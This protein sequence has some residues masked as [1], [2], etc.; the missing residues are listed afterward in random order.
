ML[1]LVEIIVI[2]IN[3]FALAMAKG[4]GKTTKKIMVFVAID[5]QSELFSFEEKIKFFAH[6]NFWS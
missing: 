6:L 1:F 4:K 5:S 3:D 2:K